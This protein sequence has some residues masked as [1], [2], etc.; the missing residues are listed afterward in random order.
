MDDTAR[1]PA[2]DTGDRL[3]GLSADLGLGSSP[4]S[5]GHEEELAPGTDLGGVVIV[6]LLARGGMGSVYEAR[7]TSPARTVAVK[8]V[9]DGR[10]GPDVLRRF[11]DEAR[12]LARLRHPHVAQIHACGT[13][14]A[15]RGTMPYIVMELVEA[16]RSITEHAAG[17]PIRE[18]VSLV[19][20]AAAAV[21]HGHGQGV[22]HRDLKPGNI[23]VDATGWVKVI[24]FGVARSVHADG[25]THRGAT[26]T[27]DLVGTLRYMSPEQ[28]G[29]DPDAVDARTDVYA[30]GLVL[31]ELVAGGLPYDLQGKSPVEAARILDGRTAPPTATVERAARAAGG[32]RADETRSLAAIVAK[33]LEPRPADRY[34]TAGVV[35]AELGRWLAG[36]PVHARPLTAAESLWRLA[37]KH[38]AVVAAAAVAL[39]SLLAA[40]AGITLFSLRAEGQRRAAVAARLLAETRQREADRQAAE[41]RGQLYL[42]TVL[43]A[44][45]ARE[46]DN[47]AEAERLLAAAADLV[48]AA[49]PGHPVELDCLAASLD[50][51]IATHPGHHDTVNAVAW[52]PD[53]ARLATGAADG[54]VRVHAAGD[55]AEGVEVVGPGAAV[56]AVT[57][58]PDGGRL[59]I[60]SADSLVRILDTA[61][62]REVARLTGHDGAAYAAA[63]APDGSL[64]ATA[65]RDGTT[66]LHDTATWR[67]RAVLAGHEGTVYAAAFS[68]DG[69]RLATGGQD[70]VVR[71]WDVAT[72]TTQH[73]LTG[74]EGRVFRVAF[75]AAGG[76]L[77]TAAE[78][79]T[80]RV[81]DLAGD[82]A[83]VVVRHPFRVNGVAFVGD[84]RR[85]ATASADG[86]LRIHDAATGAE[87]SR[88][89]G[90]AGPLWSLA[91]VPGTARAATGSADGTAREWDLDFTV[92]PRADC[93]GKVLAAAFAPD[94]RRLAVG[95]GT[96]EVRLYDAATMLPAGRLAT[97]AGRVNDVAFAPDGRRVAAAGD[98]GTVR[99]WSHHSP[100][101]AVIPAHRRRVYAV[102][103]AADGRLATASE[104]RTARVW[105]AVGGAAAGPPLR[106]P[107]RVFRVAFA[108]GDERLATA[109]EDR[110]VR[111]WDVASGA[112]VRRFAGHEGAVNW[113]AFSPAGDRLAS[114]SSDGTVRLWSVADGGPLAVLTGPA[115]QV[116][117][118]AFSPDGSRVAA[119]SA[120]GTAQVWVVASG[121]PAALLRG[122]TDQ[123]WAVAFA[124]DGRS[125]VTGGWDGSL[126]AWGVSAAEIARRRRALDPP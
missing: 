2:T 23:L 58:S 18:R 106:H 26:A 78:D 120:D 11:A 32:L 123:V 95:T 12:A 14:A 13:F 82:T 10:L 15:P 30:L 44:A 1:P 53:G 98:D 43:L 108:P 97:D 38:K 100:A 48:A 33:C 110:L 6:R 125:L 104:D 24:D 17:R 99:I 116:W 89:R 25:T 66:R 76:R 21:A 67:E 40:L 27:G 83:T 77:A 4:W 103:F 114:G 70:G 74:H 3:T 20:D 85:I 47:L 50:D 62:W 94:G 113:V 84:D 57:F 93:G 63:F 111:L 56:W 121:R 28:L 31:H 7:Q 102:A 90:H 79:G 109:G 117:K 91:I 64:L 52:S 8:V 22:V 73:T 107:K 54:S 46:R 29:A 105:D 112:E 68:P 126:R 5:A 60:A 86:M 96:A 75:A 61:G 39:A 81:W 124:P 65:G 51:S 118:V 45:E 88:L 42:S 49:G 87:V 71:L 69:A 119:V 115:R 55:G 34:P 101:A 16:A 9:R 37:A 59:A 72:G 80:A 35:E 122:H 41:A 36:E 92:A 19:H